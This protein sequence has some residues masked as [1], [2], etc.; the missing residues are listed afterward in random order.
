M[1]DLGFLA[2]L[3]ELCDVTFMVGPDKVLV[4]SAQC[5]LYSIFRA[6]VL[7]PNMEVSDRGKKAL[8]SLGVS[9]EIIVDVIKMR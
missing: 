2:H 6:S 1:A 4:C 9:I 8:R 7:S 5:T 3:P